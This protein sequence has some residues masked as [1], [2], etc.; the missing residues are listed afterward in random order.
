MRT[1]RVWT[2]TTMGGKPVL[3]SNHEQADMIYGEV[4][5]VLEAKPVLDVLEAL[6]GGEADF[7]HQRHAHE[8][9]V[10]IL[11]EHGRLP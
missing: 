3:S 2:L 8:T 7:D 4:V 5:K 10:A 11:R 6:S 9:A 1:P